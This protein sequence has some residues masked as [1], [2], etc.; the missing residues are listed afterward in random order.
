MPLNNSK[1][2]LSFRAQVFILIFP[3]KVFVFFASVWQMV[4]YGLKGF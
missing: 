1:K 2:Y 3:S 4:L